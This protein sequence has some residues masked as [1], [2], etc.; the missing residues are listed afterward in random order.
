MDNNLINRE[1]IVDDFNSILTSFVEQL[2]LIAPKSTLANNIVDVRKIL[3]NK[4]YR[5]TFINK[6]VSNILQYKAKFE[7]RDESFFLNDV[8]EEK[9]L[10]N[11]ELETNIAASKS[12]IMSKIFEFKGIWTKLSKVNKDT[13]FDYMKL[14][15]DISQEYF[16]LVDGEP[17]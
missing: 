7:A 16:I 17:L 3:K 12:T 8:F 13:M 2:I 14:L 10:K 15:C 9:V 4:N 1:N 6:F 11:K 5:E